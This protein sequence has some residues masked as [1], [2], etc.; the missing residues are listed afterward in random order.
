[1]PLFEPMLTYCEFKS[2]NKLKQNLN[3]NT[4]IFI[5][6]NFFGNIF[7]K[8]VVLFSLPQWVNISIAFQGPL[9]HL[10]LDKM[11]ATSQKTFLMLMCITWPQWVNSGNALIS[12]EI[13]SS[14]LTQCPLEDW[15]VILK[16]ILVIGSWC[17]SSEISSDEYHWT[18]L[19]ASKHWFR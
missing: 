2:L 8:T 13:S 3:E 7:S 16:Q 17:I 5:E 15:N 1:M 19:M 9:T 6:R 11:A 14:I 12:C 18:I 10:P 4:T